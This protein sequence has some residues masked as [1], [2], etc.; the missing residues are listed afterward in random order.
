MLGLTVFPCPSMSLSLR[1]L[2]EDNHSTS[3]KTVRQLLNVQIWDMISN[4]PGRSDM[5]EVKV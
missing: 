4:C 1:S 3:G 2:K 5:A